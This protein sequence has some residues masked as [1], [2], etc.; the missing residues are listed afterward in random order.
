MGVVNQSVTC[1]ARIARRS[2]RESS[3]R[4]GRIA[5][6]YVMV[7]TRAA[8]LAVRS[9]RETQ[10]MNELRRNA[11]GHHDYFGQTFFGVENRAALVGAVRAL[12]SSLAPNWRKGVFTGDNLLTYGKNLSFLGDEQFMAAV[13][14]HAGTEVERSIIWRTAVLC[15]AA[16]NGLRREG[17]FVECGCY[18][19]T[20]ARIVA[21]VVG[22]ADLPRQY[23][24]YDLFDYPHGS[25]HTHMPGMGEELFES[26]RQRF[27][28]LPNVHVIRGAVPQVLEGQSPDTIAFLHIDM[29]SAP[30]EIGAL[31][32]LFDRVSPGGVIVLDDYGYHGYVAQRDAERAWF[33]ARGYDVIELPTSQGLVIK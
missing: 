9:Y 10:Q 18:Q 24:L 23:W 30:A 3:R 19:G 14:K 4:S 11:D 28:E 2:I 16:R 33:G 29:N 7:S 12:L 27:S 15:W 25:S 32:A 22:M 26:T 5:G 17:D 1:A 21:D 13:R 20:S 31:E 6:G 8:S